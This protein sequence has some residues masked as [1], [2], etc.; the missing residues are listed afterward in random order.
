M[1]ITPALVKQLR[2]QTGV[3]MSKC[4]EALEHSGGDMEGAVA[5]LRK[6]GMS[7]AAKKE[8]RAAKEGMIIAHETDNV[9]AIAEVNAE[10]DFVVKNDRFQEFCRAIA[11]EVAVKKPTSLEEFMQQPYSKDAQLTVD[12]FRSLLIQ[13]IGENIQVRRVAF[14]EKDKEKSFGVYSHI[15]GKILSIV[16]LKGEGEE[17][18][19]RHIAMHVAAA[20]PEFLSSDEIPQEIIQKEQEIA[21]SQVAG[22]P[23]NIIEKILEGKL[24]AFFD[25]C[26]L[27]RQKYIRD[28]SLSIEQFVKKHGNSVGKDLCIEKF[29]R[30]SV[31]H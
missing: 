17:P 15:G 18:V 5:F 6:A 4:K 12:Q 27:N 25:L 11:E 8:G 7:S 29:V 21:R 10:T 13:T 26:C 9:L 1:S 31:G 19:A 20:S 30:W 3:G 16:V 23:E 24:N 14:F 28:D 22:K 2:D